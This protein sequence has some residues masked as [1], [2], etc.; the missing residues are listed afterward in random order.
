MKSLVDFQIL[1]Q[2]DETTCGPTCL[3]AVY[4]YFDDPMDLEQVIRETPRLEDG[5][6]LAVALGTHALQRG[7]RAKIFTYNLRVFD[8]SWF[9]T[10]RRRAR[11]RIDAFAVP[12]EKVPSVDLVEKLRQQVRL[13]DG[14][15]LQ[16]ACGAYANFIEQGGQMRMHD[17]NKALIR[18]YLDR[19]MPILTGLSSTYLYQGPRERQR[20]MKPDDLRGTP[21]GH[22][23][24]LCGEKPPPR[25]LVRVADPYTPNPFA[26]QDHYYDVPFDRLICAILLGVLTYDANL[27]IIQPRDNVTPCPS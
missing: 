14:M 25:K 22:F 9:V 10:D 20:D 16:L 27:L 26:N 18:H 2:P 24:V 3:Q 8:P 17:L 1:P 15:K 19:A 12:R 4:R 11:E 21:T 7:Y 5:G 13:K 6:T 23:V